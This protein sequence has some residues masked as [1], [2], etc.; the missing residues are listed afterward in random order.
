VYLEWKILDA[1]IFLLKLL[2]M[3]NF[4]NFFNSK[5]IKPNLIV[6]INFLFLEWQNLVN[7]VQ[8]Q[9]VHARKRTKV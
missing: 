9:V 4:F 5:M 1:L 6:Q 8:V 2:K 3:M 7:M